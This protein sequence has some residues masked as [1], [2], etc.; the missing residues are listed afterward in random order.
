VEA[1]SI[2]DVVSF[3]AYQ[4]WHIVSTHGKFVRYIYVIWRDDMFWYSVMLILLAAFAGIGIWH[5]ASKLFGWY[6]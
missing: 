1:Y 3:S 2:A 4:M 6:K 5:V